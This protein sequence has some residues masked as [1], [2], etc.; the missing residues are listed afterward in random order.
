MRQGSR[1]VPPTHLE[2][3]QSG[4]V[5]LG[6][7]L[8]LRQ[9]VDAVFVHPLRRLRYEGRLQDGRLQFAGRVGVAVVAPPAA[10]DAHVGRVDALVLQDQSVVAACRR[11]GGHPLK[12]NVKCSFSGAGWCCQAVRGRGSV[13][14][15]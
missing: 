5:Y 10:L 2:D 3:V 8:L 14:L 1:A 15:K 11:N 4:P 12:L 13:V 7:H 6:R 9:V